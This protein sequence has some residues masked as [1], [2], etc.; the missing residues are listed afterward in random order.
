M[1]SVCKY[2]LPSWL[3]TAAAALTLGLLA[4]ACTT[5]SGNAALSPSGISGGSLA[6]QSGGDGCDEASPNVKVDA[7][8]ENSVQYNASPDIIN[9]VCIKAGQTTALVITADV[10]GACYSVAGI[11]TSTVTVTRTGSGRSCQGIS[12]VR[13]YTE[14]CEDGKCEPPPPPPCDPTKDPYCKP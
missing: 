8:N 2:A 4:A 14:K 12:H 7:T 10:V 13:F 11:G 5:Q 3:G 1:N 6:S 9:A